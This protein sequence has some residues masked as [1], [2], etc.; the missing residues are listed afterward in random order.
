MLIFRTVPPVRLRRPNQ[1]YVFISQESPAALKDYDP[2]VFM[3]LFNWTMTYRLD[4]DILLLYGRVRPKSEYIPKTP[5]QVQDAIRAT[6]KTQM[7]FRYLW[8]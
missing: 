2:G 8:R 7:N 3:E 6:H 4:S 1:R 5:E